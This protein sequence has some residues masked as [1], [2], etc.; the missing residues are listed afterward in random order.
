MTI[1]RTLVAV[2]PQAPP[3]KLAYDFNERVYKVNDIVD[4][5]SIHFSL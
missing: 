5:L 2:N 4:N 3:N 1:T